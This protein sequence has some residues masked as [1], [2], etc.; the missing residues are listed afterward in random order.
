VLYPDVDVQVDLMPR[1]GWEGDLWRIENME[2][3]K[4]EKYYRGSGI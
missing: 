1:E 2:K 4:A 3:V